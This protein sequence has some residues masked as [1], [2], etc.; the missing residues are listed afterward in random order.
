MANTFWKENILIMCSNISQDA[1]SSW[2]PGLPLH[3]LQNYTLQILC[4]APH[5]ICDEEG[6][7]K[8]NT[9]NRALRDSDGHIYDILAGTFLVV[10][11]GE[12]DFDSLTDEHI[13]QF[14]EH[15]KT[16]ELFV[17]INGKLMVIPIKDGVREEPARPSFSEH[18]QKA[19][20][21]AGKANTTKEGP[22][23]DRTER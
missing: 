18:V 3:I 13:Q 23:I 4:R 2:H 17:K 8:G 11:L 16:P 10:G 7:L 6:K 19:E 21:K 20:T 15:F 14:S 12:E 22:D 1:E 5:N 9:L